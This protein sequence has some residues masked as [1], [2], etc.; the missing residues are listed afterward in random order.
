MNYIGKNFLIERVSVSKISKKYGTPIY[1]YSYNRLK[2]N[3]LNLK[4][5]F[6][7]FRPLLCFS[8]K[9]NANINLLKEIKK[10]GCGADVVSIGE[11]IVALKAGINVNKIVFSGV[12]KNSKEIKYAIEKK[13]IIN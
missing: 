5:N 6:K 4:K 8:V 2:K 12:G 10:L 11:L 9:S 1:C 7:S 13:N 3:V